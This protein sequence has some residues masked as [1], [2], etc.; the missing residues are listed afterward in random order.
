MVTIST[1]SA[2][3]GALVPTP[4]ERTAWLG[5]VCRK[6]TD[7][8]EF[9]YLLLPTQF[10]RWF[11]KGGGKGQ[12]VGCKTQSVPEKLHLRSITPVLS[13]PSGTRKKVSLL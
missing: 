3:R 4:F 6:R 7:G 10:R 8:S 2:G 9:I 5:G 13:R 11:R 12:D 1:V